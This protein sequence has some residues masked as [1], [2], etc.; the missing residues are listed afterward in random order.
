MKLLS[1]MSGCSA[2]FVLLIYPDN[3][4][5]CRSLVSDT[6]HYK[7]TRKLLDDYKRQE[8]LAPRYRGQELLPLRAILPS[9]SIMCGSMT[10][11]YFSASAGTAPSKI[12]GCSPRTLNL[13]TCS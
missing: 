2:M 4:T 9:L 12:A 13:V 7:I 5:D 6:A 1:R 10:L 8:L 11:T 3:Q